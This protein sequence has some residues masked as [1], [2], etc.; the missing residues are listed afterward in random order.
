MLRFELLVGR[1]AGGAETSDGLATPATREILNS[2]RV[3]TSKTPLSVGR[4]GK[5]WCDAA[6]EATVGVDGVNS[7]GACGG[8]PS[9]DCSAEIPA[10]WDTRFRD[11]DNSVARS[12]K[13]ATG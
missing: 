10:S 1:K 12:R 3:V 8:V 5:R 13:C 7:A 9:M 6:K 11:R 4:D 2:P